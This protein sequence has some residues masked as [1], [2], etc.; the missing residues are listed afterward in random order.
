MN[1]RL[2]D[3]LV[4][5]AG[6][7]LRFVDAYA[8]QVIVDGLRC[9]LRRR[10]DQRQLGISTPTP[11][12]IHHWPGLAAPWRDP[13]TSPPQPPADALAE[14]L[15]EDA[16]QRFLPLR[17]AWPAEPDT[18]E[19]ALSTVRLASA[20]QRRPPSG[21]ATVHALLADE[22]GPAAWAR[23]LASDAQGRSTSGM[24]DGEGRLTLHLPF[25]RPERK[26]PVSP[27][28]AVLAVSGTITLRVF[29]DPAIGRAALAS[30]A[31]W[32]ADWLAQPEVRALARTDAADAFGPLRLEPGHPAV[33]V[34]EGLPPD[35]SELRLAPF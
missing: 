10:R 9:I 11:S 15:V 30:G 28:E 33:A 32:L 23:V 19:T 2:L 4:I 21:A 8:G 13:A 1:A 34:T 31:P 7:G 14:V 29:H 6:C 18:S 26:P 5:P 25:P 3:T 12:G 27:P 24:S 22:A 16:L 35:R 20:P 17:L